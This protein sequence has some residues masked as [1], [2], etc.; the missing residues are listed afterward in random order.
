MTAPVDEPQRRTGTAMI[1][2]AWIGVFVLGYW[3]FSHGGVTSNRP[4]ATQDG[5]DVVLRRDRNGGYFARGELNGRPV[6]FHVDTGADTVALSL[7]LAKELQL[8]LNVQV[9]ARTAN[10]RTTGYQTR[11]EQLRLGSIELRDV[12]AIALAG[13]DDHRDVV[14]F[15]MNALKRLE[16]TQRDGQLV[17][18]VPDAAP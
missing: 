14:L 11:I 6:S 3:Y 13:M 5:A 2:V 12:S 9:T 16:F 18:R 10:G 1:W 4:L 17:L 8:S 7:Q 15:G